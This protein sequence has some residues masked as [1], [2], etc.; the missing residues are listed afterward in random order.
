MSASVVKDAV[1]LADR[2]LA[3]VRQAHRAVDH[4]FHAGRLAD[5]IEL[6]LLG[7]AADRLAQRPRR[8]CPPARCRGL[9]CDLRTHLD[10][11]H[12]PAASHRDPV[13]AL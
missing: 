8:A 13:S 6:G 7:A 2:D 5:A 10:G 4:R 3:L 1:D 9:Y 12:G 11:C